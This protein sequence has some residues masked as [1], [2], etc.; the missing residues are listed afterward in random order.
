MGVLPGGTGNG[1]A[2]EMGT[3]TKLRPALE[4]LCTDY[5]VRHVDVVQMDDGYFIQ[6]LYVGIEPEEQTNRESK[7]KYGTFRLCY[8][9][10]SPCEEYQGNQIQGGN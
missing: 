6:R 9:F 8:R 3:P 5:K 7:D 4:L 2:N 1:F 10:L